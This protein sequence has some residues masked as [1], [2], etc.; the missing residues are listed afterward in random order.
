MPSKEYIAK[1]TEYLEKELSESTF[2]NPNYS[3]PTVSVEKVYDSATNCKVKIIV[4]YDSQKIKAHEENIKKFFQNFPT[5]DSLMDSANQK[6]CLMQNIEPDNESPV[7]PTGNY[8]T[9]CFLPIGRLSSS[10]FKYLQ[11]NP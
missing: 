5:L 1:I 9:C 6:R 10:F 11:P 7:M 3:L 2:T 8:P 4:C